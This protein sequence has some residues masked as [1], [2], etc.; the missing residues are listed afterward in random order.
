MDPSYERRFKKGKTSHKITRPG[1][2]PA[3]KARPTHASMEVGVKRWLSWY[4]WSQSH[5][6]KFY[7]DFFAA[8]R[9]GGEK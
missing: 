1:K 7:L 9:I 2:E 6:I 4:W 5:E 3:R 8:L